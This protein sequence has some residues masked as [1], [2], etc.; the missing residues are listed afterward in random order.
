MTVSEYQ[1][2]PDSEVVET[3]Y[4]SAKDWD[5]YMESFYPERIEALDKWKRS[6]ERGMTT[7][8]KDRKVSKW[9]NGSYTV[10]LPSSAFD[11]QREEDFREK[12]NEDIDNALES[13]ENYSNWDTFKDSFKSLSNDSFRVVMYGLSG[14]ATKLA[15]ASE[16]RWVLPFLT[17]PLILEG[18]LHFSARDSREKLIK[19]L[20]EIKKEGNVKFQYY[21]PYF[22]RK[23]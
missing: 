21:Q 8:E 3:A 17:V 5:S 1:N 16:P 9:L 7:I 2:I 22:V 13:L 4:P 14:A 23:G 20:K 19:S 10:S 12:I 18:I 11:E 6:G 15:Y